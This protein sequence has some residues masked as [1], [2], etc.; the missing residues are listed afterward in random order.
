MED[1][2]LTQSIVGVSSNEIARDLAM[3]GLG[4]AAANPQ[5]V[6]AVKQRVNTRIKYKD[7][8]L[9]RAKAYLLDQAKNLPVTTKSGIARGE[10]KVQD[11]NFYLRKSINKAGKTSLVKATDDLT[12]GIKNFD[13]TKLPVNC[14]VKRI[15]LTYVASATSGSPTE[16]NVNYAPITASTIDE[17]FNAEFRIIVGGKVVWNGAASDF[18]NGT[19]GVSDSPAVGVNLDTLQLVKNDESIDFEIELPDGAT[20]SDSNTHFVEVKL[21]AVGIAEEV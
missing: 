20:I 10:V 16:K 6:E 12:V 19:P 17:I 18:Q 4:Q 14:V 7:R 2:E 9:T 8:N 21:K 11:F 15:E 1:L 13:K 5:A 3:A